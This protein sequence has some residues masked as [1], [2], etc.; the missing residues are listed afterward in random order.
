MIS[1][2]ESINEL[3]RLNE[4]WKV[5]TECYGLAIRSTGHYAVEVEDG[6]ARDF[7]RQLESLADALQQAETPASIREL[8]AAFRGELRS[9][10][11]KAQD[12]LSRLHNEVAAAATVMESLATSVA[13]NGDDQEARLERELAALKH[14]LASGVA[15]ELQSAVRVAIT[16]ITNCVEAM[17]RSNL[18][19]VAQLQD[20][21]RTL[22]RELAQR[23]RAVN[24]DAVT[25][26]WNAIRI[27]A[28]IADLAGLDEPFCVA[29][30]WVRNLKDLL[31]SNSRATVDRALCNLAERL[32]ESVG[33]QVMLGRRR[34]DQFVAILRDVEPAAATALSSELTRKLSGAYPIQENGTP[35]SVTLQVTGAAVERSRGGDSEIFGKQLELL[36]GVLTGGRTQHLY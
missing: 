23:D 34:D 35:V 26:L 3:D 29:V 22:H 31:S 14:A 2:H 16:G 6:Y 5:T 19:T 7:C 30:F 4:L 9:Y 8:Q 24:C 32:R 36:S 28:S 17:R 33:D 27:D 10:R 21:L 12:D 25:G 18:L 11:E 20:E 1:L 13:S 15:E